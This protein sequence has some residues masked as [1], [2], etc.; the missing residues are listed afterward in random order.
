MWMW[1]SGVAIGIIFSVLVLPA[2]TEPFPTTL[3]VFAAL[4]PVVT[5]LSWSRLKPGP[6]RVTLVVMLAGCLVH[7]IWRD[8]TLSCR[9]SSCCST[10]RSTPT[11]LGTR[12][13]PSRQPIGDPL[14]LDAC[15]SGYT[16]IVTLVYVTN[17]Q[18]YVTNVKNQVT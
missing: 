3:L 10:R 4:F 9:S 18:F 5:G 12:R 7:V 6:Y 13:R 14:R 8:C 2:L 11:C 17:E 15:S 16:C 1:V